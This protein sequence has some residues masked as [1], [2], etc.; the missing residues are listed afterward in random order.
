MLLCVVTRANAELAVDG[1]LIPHS[2]SHLHVKPCLVFCFYTLHVHLE[3]LELF[4]GT[5]DV[6]GRSNESKIMNRLQWLIDYSFSSQ[7]WL[8]LLVNK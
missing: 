5:V 3:A 4:K 1:Q 7:Q 6:D 2:V 8:S